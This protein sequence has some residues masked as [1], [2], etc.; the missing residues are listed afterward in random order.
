MPKRKLERVPQAIVNFELQ[1]ADS[2][3][4][5]LSRCISPVK[6][7]ATTPGEQVGARG[8]YGAAGGLTFYQME[9]LGGLRIV[10][11]R[12]LDSLFFCFPTTGSVTFHQGRENIL[13]SASAAFAAEVAD[14]D[15]LE[16]SSAQAHSAL[17]ID[18]PLLTERLS[19]LLD[20]PIMQKPIFEPTIN[21]LSSRVGALKS[22]IS[23][24][25]TPEFG[26]ELN[27]ARQTLDRLREM[28]IDMVLETWPNSYSEALR[29][30]PPMITPRHVKLAIDFIHDYPYLPPSGKELAVLTGVSLRSLQAGFR[31]FVGTSIK[32]YEGQVRLEGA[33][34]DLMSS[35][36]I[37]IEEI[38]LRWGFTNAGRFT[39]YFRAAYGVSPTT[40]MTRSPNRR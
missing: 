33:R 11:Q 39:R 10:P 21:P 26:F 23:L 30:P 4:E 31:Q 14:C 25:T 9:F 18:R 12:R 24:I 29:Q 22:F 13:G 27:H 2:L 34:E 1:D 37:S 5:T 3:A 28:L 32:T 16:V 36:G 40:L 8:L 17:V 6:I 35:S 20:R 15:I 19:V 7:E 38:A